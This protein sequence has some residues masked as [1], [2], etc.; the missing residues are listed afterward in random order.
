MIIKRWII[1]SFS[2]KINVNYILPDE[3]ETKKKESVNNDKDL[4]KQFYCKNSNA[5]EIILRNIF[6]N[7]TLEND[8]LTICLNNYK[9]SKQI[10]W[11]K[12]WWNKR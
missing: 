9:W 3:E 8:N 1:I 11:I 5:K 12:I 2:L 6:F 7:W 4:F 10:F